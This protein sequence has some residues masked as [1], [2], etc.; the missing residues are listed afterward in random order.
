MAV[1]DIFSAITE[2][3]PYR[4][5]MDREAAMEVLA[6]DVVSGGIDGDLVALLGERYEE[7]DAAREEASRTEGARYYESIRQPG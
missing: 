6:G 3:R 7:V 1:A 4:A 5:G 2:L